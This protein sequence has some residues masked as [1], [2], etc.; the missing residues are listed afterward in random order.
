MIAPH[1]APIY[2]VAGYVRYL[3]GG[4]A[5]NRWFAVEWNRVRGDCCSGDGDEEYT[6]EAILH[7]SGDIVFQ[8]TTMTTRGNFWCQASGVEDTTGLDGL[9]TS[10]WCQQVAPNHAVRITRPAAAARVALVPRAQGTFGAAGATVRFDQTVRNTGELGADTYDFSVNSSWPTA[11]YQAGGS[12]LLTD[13]DG[14]GKVDTGPIAQGGAA[15]IV[16]KVTLPTDATVGASREA[17][18]TAAS[19]RDPMRMQTVRF[20]TGVPAQFAQTYTQSG[21]PRVG[22]YRP[23]QQATHQT[24][25]QYGDDPAVATAPDGSIV[26]VWGQ[27]HSLSSNRYV[28][29]LYSAVLDGRG[30]VVRPAA[31][32]T[33]LSGA[34]TD[35]YDYNP[36]VAVTPDG[37]IGIVWYRYLWNRS[38]STSNYNIYFM[39][40]A[41]NGAIVSAPTN[42]TNNSSWGASGTKNLPRFY[43]PT[44]AATA[45]GRFGLAWTREVYTGSEWLDTTWYA[46]RRGDGGQ[47]KAPTQFSTNTRSYYPNLTSLADGTLFLI[48][49][50]DNQLGYGRINSSGGIVTGQTTLSASYPQYPD[51]IQLPNGNIV[52]AWSQGNIRYAV[53][54]PGLGIVK[55]VSSLPNMSPI[56]D[57]YVSVTRSGNRAVLTWGDGCCGYQPNLYYALLDGEGNVVT[58]PMIF[59]SD[60]AD[61]S[62]Q[63]SSSGQGNAPLLGDLSGPT[64]PTGLASPS[65]ALNFWSSDTTV[66]VAWT[67]ATDESGLAG[68]SVAWDHAAATVPDTTQDIGAVTAAISP[69]L[70]DGDWYFHIRPVDTAGNWAVGAAHLGPFRID[71]TPP[72]SAVS[73]PEFIIGPIPVTWSGTD[74]G[75]GIAAYDVWVRQGAGGA[76]TKWLAGTTA[77]SASYPGTAGQ[78]YTFRSVARDATGNI[79]TDVPAGGDS[80]STVAGAQATGRVTNNR[81]QPIAGANVI[82]NPTALNTAHSNML[83]NYTLYFTSV[84]MSSAYDLT[85]SRTGFSTLP[86]RRGVEVAFASTGLDFVLPPEI[87]AVVNGGFETGDLSGWQ[88]APGA[89]AA[90]KASAAHT[91]LGGLQL[92]STPGDGPEPLWQVS[93]TITL[94]LGLAAPTLSWFTQ[95]ASG[96]PADR[97]VVEVSNGADAITRTIPLAAGLWMH[98]WEDLSAFAGQTVTLR[99]GCRGSAAHWVFLDEINIGATQRGSRS[100]YLPLVVK[101][102]PQPLRINMGS[103][104]ST[105]DPQ[106]GSFVAEISN[107]R[108][109]YEGLTGLDENLETV[110]GAAE[111]WAYNAAATEL[112]FTLR[113]GLQYSDGTPLNAKRYAFSILRNIDPTTQ[114]EYASITDEIVGAAAYRS[115]DAGNLTPAQLQQLRDAVAVRALDGS[116]QPCASYTQAD[117]RTLKLRFTRPARY[118]HTVMSLWVTFP[119]KEELIAA[120]GEEWW[121]SPQ[122]QIGNGPFVMTVNTADTLTR[123]APNPRYWKGQAAYGIEYRY[124]ADSAAAFAAYRAGDLDIVALSPADRSTV[125]GDPVLRAQLLTYPGSCTYALMFHNL[126]PPF[127]D[128]K[129]RQAFAYAL[130]REAWVRDVLGGAGSPTL[131]WIPKGYPGYDATE[132]RWGYNP[133]LARQALAASSYGSAANL[134]PITATF[135][136]TPRNRTRWSWLINQFQ[137]VLG[138]QV[139]F[140]PVS[141]SMSQQMYLLGWC[142][143]YPD[144]QNWLSV[145]WRT[146]GFGARIG[147]SNPAVDALLDQADAEPDQAT[148]MALYAQAQQLITTDLPAAYLWNNINAYLVN[149]RVQGVKTTPQDS[150]WAGSQVPLSITLR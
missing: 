118:F 96:D 65:H 8:Y 16:V 94:P 142:A 22:L 126:K 120:G 128:P 141:S 106:K 48:Q 27:G 13:T 127:T 57:Y 21:Q 19:S 43:Y 7:E 108:L 109:I 80:H 100:V 71:A 73:S 63:L 132:A 134:P 90:V 56:N 124:M 61:Y 150:D 77:T 82:A 123:F 52:I 148:R 49:R 35:A 113:A 119:A 70:A 99:I 140:N 88:L 137:T 85:A 39:V 29:E 37:R 3:R 34:S 42:L 47:V 15:S 135:T 11:L 9:S 28:V 97:L 4:T 58:W 81:G 122:Y 6:F 138:V 53:L 136:D 92:L 125:E 25:N 133:D 44:I 105:M 112:T 83:G 139:A 41:A 143:D 30:N 110:P 95:V 24:T 26:Q 18:V 17:Q 75:S 146:G 14:D 149:P 45:D 107:M 2:A 76:W 59:F 116:G 40:L 62:V 78:T 130:D 147:Y 51:A 79:E 66:D 102:F 121:R 72:Q 144:P 87:D 46:V 115:A 103:Y 54:S 84:D 33:D 64:G 32:L 36:A 117:C 145:Y 104:P 98:A 38:N 67:A 93:Q 86:A 1:W 50:A 111:S 12:T 114:G 68:Y 20:Q 5:P 31:R 101:N 55:N 129:V 74:A 23:D 69:A 131:T 10:P 91:G 60:Y 89:T